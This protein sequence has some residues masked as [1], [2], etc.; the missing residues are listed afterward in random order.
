MKMLC[1]DWMTSV[2]YFFTVA[3]KS[4]QHVT[5]PSDGN[6]PSLKRFPAGN[7]SVE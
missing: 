5:I 4:W 3:A 7:V 1:V 2:Y 6:Y